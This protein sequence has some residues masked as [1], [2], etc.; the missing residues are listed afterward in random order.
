MIKFVVF[1]YDGVFTDGSVIFDNDNNI[2]KRYNVIDGVGIKELKNKG[3]EVGCISGYKENQS[4]RNILEHLNIKYISMGSNDK[5]NILKSWIELL[6]ITIEEVAFMGD[7]MN[8][9]EIMNSVKLVG[10]PKNAHKDCLELAQFISEKNGGKGCV[11]EFCDYILEMNNIKLIVVIPTRK[12]STR[13]KNKNTRRFHDTTLLDIVLNKIITLKNI[14]KI[15]VSSNCE[16]TKKIV[17]KY[18]NVIYDKRDEKFCTSDCKPSKWNV[19]IA[20]IVKRYNGNHILFCHCV[21]PFILKNTYEKIIDHFYHNYNKYDTHIL[22]SK[23]N[24]FIWYN[25]N[26][27]NYKYGDSMP[28]SQNLPDYLTPCWGAVISNVDNIIKNKSL[29][30]KNPYFLKINKIQAIDID[31]NDEFI[32]SELLYKNNL[33]TEENINIYNN[34]KLD[35]FKLLDCTIRDGGYTNNWSFTDDFVI[36]LYNTI[37]SCNYDYFE[38]GFRNSLKCEGKGKYYNISDKDIEFIYNKSKNRCKISIMV[39]IDR[40]KLSDFKQKKDTKID[41]IRILIHR[42][43]QSYNIKEAKKCAID[44][45][46]KGYDVCINLGNSEKLSIEEVTNIDYYFKDINIKCIYLADTFGSI[47]EYDITKLKIMFKYNKLGFHG[48]NNKNIC[49]TNTINA[50]NDGFIMIDTTF[51]SLGKN[52]GNCS[53]ESIIL[54]YFDITYLEYILNIY[55]K[56]NEI[57]DNKCLKNLLYEISGIYNIHSDYMNDLLHLDNYDLYKNITKLIKYFDKN[58]ILKNNSSYD[59][60]LIKNII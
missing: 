54:T 53:T 35:D 14:Y 51:N 58:N 9:I 39:T 11:R 25:N 56:Y 6:N 43:N 24:E 44:L 28:C 2:I 52:A 32:I 46:E 10:C 16:E 37:S 23:I 41:L 29:L 7:D 49:L 13:V 59:I 27:L 48:H 20:N 19:E 18:S 50:I 21:C 34:N 60:N 5:L 30:G 1:D 55:N 40:F 38:I 31:T 42:E 17:D 15:I 4:Q 45:I 26:P 3:I 22:A 57:Y 12:N 36:D 8:D 33:I 47:N